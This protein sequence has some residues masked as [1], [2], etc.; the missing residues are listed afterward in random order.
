MY[1]RCGEK[2][3]FV[4]QI[5]IGE[6]HVGGWRKMEPMIASG[7]FDQLLPESG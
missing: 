3:E 4:P 7:E 6:R 2:V 1:E 5:F